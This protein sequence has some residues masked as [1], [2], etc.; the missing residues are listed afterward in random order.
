MGHNRRMEVLNIRGM[1]FSLNWFSIILTTN[2]PSKYLEQ[3][4]SWSHQNRPLRFLLFPKVGNILFHMPSIIYSLPPLP[5]F[6]PVPKIG[7][8]Y[9]YIHHNIP[10][11]IP[12]LKFPPVGNNIQFFLRN[13]RFFLGTGSCRG[14]ALE[15]ASPWPAS[16]VAPAGPPER[17]AVES[18]SP[19][20]CS[21]L[22]GGNPH[23]PWGVQGKGK[24]G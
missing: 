6:A 17:P 20:F 13:N 11:N 19:A 18:P 23:P 7:N 8:I 5:N 22:L 24:R 21:P 14:T 16:R 3:I 15:R 4:G 2:R 1:R 10:S 12:T 9:I